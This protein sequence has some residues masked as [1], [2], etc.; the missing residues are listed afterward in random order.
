MQSFTHRSIRIIAIVLAT[1][2]IMSFAAYASVHTVSATM[3]SNAYY[4]QTSKLTSDT[5]DGAVSGTV[6]SAPSSSCG[7]KYSLIGYITA[8]NTITVWTSNVATTTS[9]PV[10][11]GY[12]SAGYAA[13]AGYVQPYNTANGVTATITLS[14]R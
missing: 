13:Y 2:A 3:Q 7:A 11:S 5:G 9:G 4:L 6:T 1:F 12:L 8:L 10:G 14:T